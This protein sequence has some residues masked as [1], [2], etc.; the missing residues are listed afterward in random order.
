MGVKSV[1][2]VAVSPD[3]IPE[4][5]LGITKL[6]A[7]YVS[8]RHGE[9]DVGVVFRASHLNGQIAPVSSRSLSPATSCTERSPP[10]IRA[11]RFVDLGISIV[12]CS[13]FLVR[14]RA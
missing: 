14:A 1:F 7:A 13:S 10:R 2:P 3:R 6:G 9:I 12:T 8:K 11:Y 4:P 5:A